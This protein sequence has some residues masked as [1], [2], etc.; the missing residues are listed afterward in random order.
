MWLLALSSLHIGAQKQFHYHLQGTC[1]NGMPAA[2]CMKIALPEGVS[3]P[4]Q[5][6]QIIQ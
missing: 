3:T 2:I 6:T 1:T 4:K 5:G